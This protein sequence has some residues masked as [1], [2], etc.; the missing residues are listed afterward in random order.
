MYKTYDIDPIDVDPD[1]I[2]ENQTTAGA[3]DLVLK[4][5]KSVV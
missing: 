3:A 5:R 2:A 4:D 1:G